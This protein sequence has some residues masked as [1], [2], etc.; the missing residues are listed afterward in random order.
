LGAVVLRSNRAGVYA[1]LLSAAGINADEALYPVLSAVARLDS[2][3]VAEIAKAAGIGYTTCSRHLATL[4]DLGLVS[5]ADDAADRRATTAVL[6]EQGVVA[7][8]VMRARLEELIASC[9][10]GWSPTELTTFAAQLDRFCTAFANY[11]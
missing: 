7:V 11:R 10:D 3:R 8:A 1:D 4:A 9:V 5:R 2:A 6:T